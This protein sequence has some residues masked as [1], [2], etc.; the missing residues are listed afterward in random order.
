MRG[1]GWNTS[2]YRFADLVAGVGGCLTRK[3]G[4]VAPNCAPSALGVASRAA[5]YEAAGRGGMIPSL[6]RTSAASRISLMV[7][8]A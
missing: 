5:F 1:V 2:P 7:L 3:A 8:A 4:S 6:I